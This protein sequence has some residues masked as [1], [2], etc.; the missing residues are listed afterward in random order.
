MKNHLLGAL[1]SL[2]IVSALF[3]ALPPESSGHCDTM[4]GP[5]V[6]AARVALQK[7]DLT[8]V[9]MWVRAHDEQELRAVF[10]RTLSVRALGKDA[11]ELA[12][13]YF[14]ETLVRLHREGEGEPYT[15]LKPAGSGIHPLVKAADRAIEADSVDKVVQHITGQVGE[16][17]RERFLEAVEK[18]RHAGE[19]VQNGRAYVASYVEFIHYV[20]RLAEAAASPA[21]HAHGHGAKPPEHGH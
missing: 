21:A 17:I 18:N 8:P 6:S 4:E 1:V 20:E 10:E 12:D 14:F 9:L 7:A 19:T 5:V 2:F 11:K 3:M 16:G 13:R 15:G